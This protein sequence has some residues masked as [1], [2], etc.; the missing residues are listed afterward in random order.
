M[1]DLDRL[2][3]N[4]KRYKN[5]HYSPYY[6]DPKDR[7]FYCDITCS[8][9]FVDDKKYNVWVI[10]YN[11]WTN[12]DGQD[13]NNPVPHSFEKAVKIFNTFYPGEAEVRLLPEK[14]Q[15]IVITGKT[16]AITVPIPKPTM[17]DEE[18][19]LRKMLYPHVDAH[20]CICGI[21]RKDC[22]YHK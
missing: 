18:T 4:C 1:E 8:K 3:D 21:A 2:C 16:T 19:K 22:T 17:E 10:P 9:R 11:R 12:M 7:E 15:P 13:P 20:Q 14:F 5:V 6:V